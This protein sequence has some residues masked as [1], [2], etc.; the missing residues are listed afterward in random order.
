MHKGIVNESR[1]Q[2]TCLITV[3][4]LIQITY[5]DNGTPL[6]KLYGLRDGNPEIFTGLMNHS[7]DTIDDNDNGDNRGQGSMGP[8][9]HTKLPLHQALPQCDL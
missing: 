1:L 9:W 4:W 7:Y 8:R 6:Y 3:S 5:M 2:L